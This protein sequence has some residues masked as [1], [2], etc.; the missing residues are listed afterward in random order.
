MLRW[1]AA[2]VAGVAG[3]AQSARTAHLSWKD[4]TDLAG[5]PSPV[6][7]LPGDPLARLGVSAA[8][9]SEGTGPVRFI[10]TSRYLNGAAAVVTHTVDDST[11]HVPACLDA[12]DTYGIKS[13]VFVSTGAPAME[14][15]W[16]RLRRAIADGHEV[17]AHSRTHP[18][19][20]PDTFW[21]C[22]RALTRH[23][24]DGSRADILAHTD[25]PHVWTWAY[26]CGNCAGRG[27]VRRKVARAGYLAARAYPG[28]LQLRHI[29]PNLQT[30][31]ANPYAARYTQ[32]VQKGSALVVR[33]KGVRAIPGRTRVP[34]LNAKFDEVH[35]A[36]G[37][38]SF[39]SHP[40]LLD[41]G[42]DGFYEQH[43]AHIGGRAD[44]W[45]V[46]MGPLYSYRMLVG[47]TSVR[48]L[49]SRDARARFAVFNRLDPKIYNGSVTLEFQASAPVRVVAHGRE[50]AERAAG[51]VT[52]WN[53]EYLRRVGE[54]VLLTTRP[55]TVVEFR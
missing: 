48:P 35:A 53:A 38:Y 19:R 1:L 3:F 27:F 26:P 34:T 12:M 40:H 16:P 9:L 36:G 20:L 55:N 39:L 15:L 41:Y 25:Q 6:G 8:E 30:Y 31:D 44:V 23:E 2:H 21:F 14:A 52:R 46:P 24:I 54:R 43:L 51:P 28:E 37:I 49:A 7:V 13:T 10:R 18:C 50:V 5:R 17:G 33:G 42:P 11:A 32:V 22:F 45:Y 29:V 47:A 4:F